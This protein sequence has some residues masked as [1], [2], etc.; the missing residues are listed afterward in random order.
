MIKVEAKNKNGKIIIDD[1]SKIGTDV[2][3]RVNC[4]KTYNF[5]LKSDLTR[6]FGI[7][8]LKLPSGSVMD[9]EEIELDYQ[10]LGIGDLNKVMYFKQYFLTVETRHID[11]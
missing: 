6:N 7:G 5:N 1:F 9:A 2:G 3:A 11:Y 10:D 4:E 8:E